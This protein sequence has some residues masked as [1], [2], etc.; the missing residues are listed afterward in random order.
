M[1][2]VFLLAYEFYVLT[3]LKREI[4]TEVRAFDHDFWFE[5]NGPKSIPKRNK[6]ELPYDGSQY[7]L[8]DIISCGVTDKRSEDLEKY[9]S[10]L[11]IE[12]QAEN[13]KLFSRNCRSYS[14][15]LL[16][17]LHPT[18]SNK[19]RRYLSALTDDQDLKEKLLLGTA[20]VATSYTLYTLY[21]LLFPASQ[22][23]KEEL[24]VIYS[25]IYAAGIRFCYTVL[26]PWWYV[27]S[28]I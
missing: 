28:W 25:T 5:I 19:C 22:D 18:E 14:K 9:V 23:E 15:D 27:T 12:F 7:R 21:E 13:Y 3:P 4:H 8:V 10:D 26:W 11:E 17:F 6:E 16:S 1:T 24:W 20:G 2:P